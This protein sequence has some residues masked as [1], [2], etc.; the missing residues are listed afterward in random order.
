MHGLE[1]RWLGAGRKFGRDD[2]LEWQVTW[3][4]YRA[5]EGGGDYGREWNAS[6]G[7]VL[8]PR[9]KGLLKWAD[10]RANYRADGFAR[11][12]RKVWWQL[13]WTR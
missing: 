8:G 4:D 13:E 2:R 12:T 9:V 6:L 5:A 1:D 10:Y 7:V 3:H 11:D